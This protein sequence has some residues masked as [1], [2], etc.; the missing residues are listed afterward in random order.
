VV[1]GGLMVGGG[2][3]RV[4]ERLGAGDFVLLPA[5]MGEARVRVE[6]DAEW[7]MAEPG[8]RVVPV[9]GGGR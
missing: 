6:E 8:G 1:R 3:L 7:L 4:G 2:E 9:P 5:R